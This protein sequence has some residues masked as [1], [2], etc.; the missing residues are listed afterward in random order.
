[1]SHSYD[2]ICMKTPIDEFLQVNVPK[3][4]C[5]AVLHHQDHPVLS[6]YHVTRRIY[7]ELRHRVCWPHIATDVQN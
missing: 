3:K 4:L 2:I 5:R 1:M 6:E 7:D